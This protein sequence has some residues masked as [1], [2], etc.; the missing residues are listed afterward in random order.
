MGRSDLRDFMAEL[1]SAGLLARVA[2]PVSLV[3]EMTEIHRRVLAAKGPAILFE[4]PVDASGRA[5]N[6]PVLVNLFGTPRRVAMG[7]GG[8]FT[9][10]NGKQGKQR[11]QA[12]ASMFGTPGSSVTGAATTFT[13]LRHSLPGRLAERP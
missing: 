6:H 8:K 4:R 1:A 13:L 3:H 12:H 7:L 2:E 5:M 10:W 11:E 9:V